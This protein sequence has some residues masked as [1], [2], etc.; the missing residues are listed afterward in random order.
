MKVNPMS[1]LSQ[2]VLAVVVLMYPPGSAW[3]DDEHD[4]SRPDLVVFGDSLSDPGNIFLLT[5]QVSTAPYEVIPGAPYEIGGN[6]FSNGRTWAEALAQRLGSRDSDEPALSDPVRF[7][8]FAFGGARARAAGQAPSATD[9]VTLFLQVRGHVAA[10]EALYVVQ[11]GGNDMRDALAAA[12][13]DINLAFA[14]MSD[15]VMTTSANIDRL[16]T[17]GARRFLV[18]NVPNLGAAPA[19]VAL[20]ASESATFLTSIYNGLLEGALQALDV[21]PGIEIHRLDMFRFI[22]DV[23][24]SPDAFDIVN[25]TTPCLSF[26]VIEGAVCEEPG[27]HLFWDGIHPTRKG[28]LKLAQ[29]A[30]RVLRGSDED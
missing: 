26:G 24:A 8:N 13:V 21:A 30:V 25:A 22:N 20:G 28:H 11:F 6:H 7:D 9:Q 17:A 10:P 23:V 1:S 5:G 15:A 3:A 16:Y 19:I 14:I 27:D 12:T 4:G 2:F 29:K 18:A